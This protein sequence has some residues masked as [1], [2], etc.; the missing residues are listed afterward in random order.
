MHEYLGFLCEDAALIFQS[1]F[2]TL[3]DFGRFQVETLKCRINALEDE[4]NRQVLRLKIESDSTEQVI[5]EQE[6]HIRAVEG[7]LLES[8]VREQNL[9]SKLRDSEQQSSAYA[10]KLREAE[11]RLCSNANLSDQSDARGDLKESHS[12]ELRELIAQLLLE[13]ETSIHLRESVGSLQERLDV[14]L[15]EARRSVAETAVYKKSITKLEEHLET[16]KCLV[17]RL[18]QEVER[19]EARMQQAE[20]EHEEYKASLTKKM[21]SVQQHLQRLR[22]DRAE[23]LSSRPLLEAQVRIACPAYE[24]LPRP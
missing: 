9:G 8:Q 3:T 21:S 18:Q 22:D 10:L 11:E 19:L 13:Q 16:R 12:D 17:L 24:R 5:R 1:A 23:L 7:R 4:I 2:S 20:Q 14:A 15:H 6:Q